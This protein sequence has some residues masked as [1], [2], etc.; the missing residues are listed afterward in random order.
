M[1]VIFLEDV[2]NV[3]KAGD[4]KEVADGYGRNYLLT[5]KLAVLADSQAA[6]KAEAQLKKRAREHARLEAEMKEL[7][8]MLTGKE[9]TFK[10]KA[11]AEGKLF[12]SVT[13]ADVS[14]ELEKR[15][16]LVVDKRKVDLSEAIKQT[17]S[18]DVPIK[19]TG[20]IG[21]AIKVNVL[22]EEETK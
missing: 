14:A 12:G 19:L 21:A 22:A 2:P 18:Y 15:H 5:K 20:D 9:I 7:A 17:G 11:G 10:A 16:G 3:A 1:K 13:A 6:G 8:K 4:A